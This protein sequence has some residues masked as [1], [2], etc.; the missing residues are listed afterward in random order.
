MSGRDLLT[1]ILPPSS[2]Q[3]GPDLESLTRED[4]EAA[5]R[6]LPSHGWTAGWVG[7][8][9]RAELVLTRIVGVAREQAAEL[10]AGDIFVADAT[11]AI[12]VTS[13]EVTVANSADTLIC[14]PCALARWLHALDLAM[15]YPEHVLAATIARAA[16]LHSGSPHLCVSSL[17]ITPTTRNVPLFPGS[18]R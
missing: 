2:E 12:H 15:T 10:T 5:L 17:E 16:P 18:V 14:A 13:G 6:R 3:L 7:R 9:T 1:T 8:R 11:A 4:V